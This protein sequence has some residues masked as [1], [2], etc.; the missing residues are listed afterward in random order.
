MSHQS[1][2]LAR[3]SLGLLLSL[4][5]GACMSARPPLGLPDA[6]VDT[7]DGVAAHGP[8]CRSI[9][10]PSTMRDPDMLPHPAIP[11][12]CAN[13]ANLAAQLAR[14]ADIAQPLPYAGAD[15]TAAERA[16]QRYDNPPVSHDPS[17]NSSST[18][19]GIS[20]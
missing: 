6:S 8:D 5:L 11:F 15:G 1:L 17:Q 16:V 4:A 12:G 18:T 2:R 20:Q 19:D 13:Y 7:F 14:P 9:A 3:F 10:L